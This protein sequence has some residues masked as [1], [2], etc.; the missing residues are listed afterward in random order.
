MPRE[1]LI[2]RLLRKDADAVHQAIR[3]G[4]DYYFSPS[5]GCLHCRNL[6]SHS[7]GCN[8]HAGAILL[9]RELQ[10]RFVFPKDFT[11]ASINGD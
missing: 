8:N 2:V 3:N 11:M 1:M 4:I 7:P 6:G 5:T 9:L 10:R